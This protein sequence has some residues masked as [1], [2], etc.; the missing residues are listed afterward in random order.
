MPYRIDWEP[1]GACRTY[2]GDVTIA[3]RRDSFEAITADPRFDDLRYVLTDYLAVAS[4]EVTP[5]AT[6]EIAALHIGPVFTNPRLLIAAVATRP[7]VL[8]AIDQ[9]RRYGFTKAPYQVFS[10][11]AEARAW[12]AAQISA[13]R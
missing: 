10:T 6:A 8:A 13:A 9:F 3:E 7:D 4:Y 5:D 12:I 2:F 1:D 11:R